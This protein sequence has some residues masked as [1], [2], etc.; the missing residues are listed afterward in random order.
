M[1][2][3]EFIWISLICVNN[4]ELK[5]PAL[6]LPA[7]T[8]CVALTALLFCISF[9]YKK[10]KML[11]VHISFQTAIAARRSMSLHDLYFPILLAKATARRLR[12]WQAAIRIR[13]KSSSTVAHSNLAC[14]IQIYD[15][16]DD[17]SLNARDNWLWLLL[18]FQCWTPVEQPSMTQCVK[19][20]CFRA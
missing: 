18:V 3:S 11:N 13:R 12:W 2:P 6:P 20:L 17:V 4:S 1:E 5:A 8:G 16:E 10:K 15:D 14:V 9:L 7:P 19:A